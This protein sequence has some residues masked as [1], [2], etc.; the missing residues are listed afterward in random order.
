MER[1]I[2]MKQVDG[3]VCAAADDD[4]NKLLTHGVGHSTAGP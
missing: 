1:D 4:G 3:G 2:S